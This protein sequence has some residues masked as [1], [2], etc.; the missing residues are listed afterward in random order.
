MI[1]AMRQSLSV[2]DPAPQIAKPRYT[3]GEEIAHAVTH[4]LGIVAA[5][6][7]LTVLVAFAALRGDRFHVIGAAVFGTTMVLLYTAS[8]LYHA[9]PNIGAKKVL[10]ILDHASIYLLIAGTYTPFAL[11]SLRG[12]GGLVFLAVIWGLALLGIVVESIA[13]ERAKWVSL[14]LY[15]GMGWSCLTVGSTLMRTVPAPGM[16]LLLAGGIAYTL[17]IAFYLFR[18]LRYHH[19]IWHLFVVA[20]SV[21]HWFAVYFGVVPRP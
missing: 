8:T 10:R 19:A 13:L 16:A 12:A 14:A 3:L 5:I 17:G 21:F 2:A 6:V 9:I 15:V 11:V 7:G 18:R 4:G 1:A 20:G